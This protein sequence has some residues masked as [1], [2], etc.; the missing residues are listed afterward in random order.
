VQ[1]E[2]KRKEPRKITNTAD[3]FKYMKTIKKSMALMA[4][5]LLGA[6]TTLQA[7]Q[8]NGNI[9][10]LGT[11]NLDT[12]S[13]ATATA[14][15]GWHGNG[16]V[17]DPFVAD[18]TGDFP[19]FVTL[20]VTTATIVA[21]WSFNTGSVPSFWTAGG[22]TFDLTQSSI[23]SQGGNPGLLTVS[24]TGFISGNGFDSTP[25]VWGFST[26]DPSV[27]TP[28]RFSFSAAAAATPCTGQIGD[29]IWNDLNGNGCQDAGEPGIANVVVSL[30][31]GACGS[32]GT[33][34]ASTATDQTGHYLFI[35]LCPG[36]YQVAI[37]TPAGFGATVA[38]SGCKDANLPPDRNELDSKCSCAGVS[39]CVT[40]VT[41][42]EA[43]PINLNV[44]CGYIKLCDCL[45]TF[46]APLRI[47]NCLGDTIPGVT[48]TQVCGGGQPVNV[49]VTFSKAVTNGDCPK[50]I[51][52]TFTAVDG[53]DK[54]QT[55]VQTLTLNCPSDCKSIKASVT[56]AMAG[57][58]GYTAS[59]A[60]AGSGANYL[61]TITNGKITAGA[62]TSSITWTAGTDTNKPVGI[63]VT[64]STSAGCITGPCCISVPLKSSPTGCTFT[65]GGWGAG[66][67]GNNPGTILTNMFPKLYPKGFI[68]GGTYTMKFSYAANIT[69]YLPAG[70]TPGVLK[71]SYTNPT[72]PTEAGEFGSQVMCLKLNID[73]SNNGYTKPGLA[74]LKIAPGY[75]LAGTKLSDLL[76][77]VNKVLGGQT[78][79]LPAG[80]SVSDLT[81]LMSDIAGNFDN[82][83][84]NNGVLV[85]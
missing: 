57:V 42:T 3:E 72:S 28:A 31:S 59:V 38:N 83:T 70:T 12:G 63:C 82:C 1:T 44:D 16:G 18:A 40:C 6:A 41:L 66:P 11:A 17:G 74:N 64:V 62:G 52:R 24:G 81:G 20:G 2:L 43:A 10:F 58:T 5:A 36:D 60:D 77:L 37:T 53:C 9:S 14:V 73:A 69:A 8:V 56:S 32:S 22:F 46:N 80:V 68:V 4:T 51:T 55:F 15:T 7:A 30:Y 21:P 61:W 33:L 34:I 75:P 23:T 49:Q 13:A 84:N 48:A 25:G 47:T 26:Q 29:F 54:L 78:S 85:F 79:A 76:I 67:S 27:G 19:A 35:G 45:L 65:P 39:P 71:K 50:I